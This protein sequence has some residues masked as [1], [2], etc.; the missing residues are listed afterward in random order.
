MG[1]LGGGEVRKEKL[2]PKTVAKII[3]K[4]EE[5]K[6]KEA[7]GQRVNWPHVLTEVRQIVH[8]AGNKGFFERLFSGRSSGTQ[9]FYNAIIANISKISKFPELRVKD[10]EGKGADS[11]GLAKREIGLA[12]EVIAKQQ[13]I[14]DE[15]ESL[16][17]SEPTTTE[18]FETLQAQAAES[19]S[20]EEERWE[21]N[22]ANRY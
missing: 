7:Q 17:N 13:R 20:E 12:E 3:D 6:K 9:E 2:V 15:L 16:K 18:S 4:I 19:K 10:S 8:M 14:K 22:F 1:L 5:A 21:V 11:V